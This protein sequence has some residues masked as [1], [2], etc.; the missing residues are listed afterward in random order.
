M[1]TILDFFRLQN[2][3]DSSFKKTI[4]LFQINI[5]IFFLL[6]LQIMK[7]HIAWLDDPSNGVLHDGAQKI[8]VILLAT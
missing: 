7:K 6:H 4:S 1:F 3:F 2:I 5:N 8:L